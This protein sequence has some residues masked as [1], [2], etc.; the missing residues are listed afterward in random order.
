MKYLLLLG[1]YGFQPFCKT[2]CDLPI[3]V[4]KSLARAAAQFAKQSAL[5]VP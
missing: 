2:V 1:T 4:K 5:S 3:H